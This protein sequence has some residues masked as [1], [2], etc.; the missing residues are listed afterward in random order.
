[1]NTE[2]RSHLLPDQIGLVGDVHGNSRTAASAIASC[3]KAGAEEIHFLGDFGVVWE[4]GRRQQPELDYLTRVLERR[5]RPVTAYI[6]GG[7]HDGYTEW[8]K[9]PA[10]PDGIRWA[11]NRI[12]L[13]PRG[14]RTRSSSGTVL[15]SL[16]GANS[17]DRKLRQ[18][19]GSGWWAQESITEADLAAVG[20]E[21][22]DILL[23][24]DAPN[25]S[26]LRAVLEPDESRWD[27]EDL[28]YAKSG[29]AMFHRAVQQVRP[30]LT[31]SGHYHL[32]LDTVEALT[33]VNGVPFRTRSVIL[34][35]DGR[36]PT[37]AV[38]DTTKN[39]VRFLT[40]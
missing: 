39:E 23:G 10:A 38:L 14:W 5:T 34:N 6:T 8:A 13:L 24:H 36:R 22:V 29:Q 32:H 11:T 28:A 26:A 9:Y 35:A 31:V 3:V 40:L 15:V 25:T 37:A 33:D 19:I 4:G 21:P 1:M 20:N 7:N 27:V 18:Q 16:G 17:I 2:V 12:G 30:R